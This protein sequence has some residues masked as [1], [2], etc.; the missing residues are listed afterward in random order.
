MTRCSHPHV[1]MR[2]TPGIATWKVGFIAVAPFAVYLLCCAMLVVV[3]T[4]GISRPPLDSSFGKRVATGSRPNR[5]RDCQT[6]TCA[7]ALRRVWLI[8][9]PL[10]ISTRGRALRLRSGQRGNRGD[11]RKCN[12][13]RN[14]YPMWPDSKHRANLGSLLPEASSEI[15]THDPP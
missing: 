4:A 2:G 5:P 3:L 6:F 13:C 7:A 8:E 11:G 14:H 12:K 9:W 15:K 10:S 1:E